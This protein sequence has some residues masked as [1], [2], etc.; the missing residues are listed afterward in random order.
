M[1]THSAAQ[2]ERTRLQSTRPAVIARLSKGAY[3]GTAPDD[4]YLVTKDGRLESENQALPA[5]SLLPGTWSDY[6][7]AESGSVF[8]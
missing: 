3:G 4:W 1:A 2:G 8:A 7:V 5:R 6:T